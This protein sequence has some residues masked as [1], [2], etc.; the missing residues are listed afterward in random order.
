MF[1]EYQSLL[2]ALT[3]KN[4]QTFVEYCFWL[5]KIQWFPNLKTIQ[6]HKQLKTSDKLLRKLI[7]YINTN[8]WFA[9][10]SWG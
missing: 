8:D 6:G 1:F 9:L 7:K 2:E 10:L 4:Y 3:M 5:E